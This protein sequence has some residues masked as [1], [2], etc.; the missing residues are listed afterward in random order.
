M[1]VFNSKRMSISIFFIVNKLFKQINYL[2]ILNLT[3]INISL[4]IYQIHLCYQ[5]MINSHKIKIIIT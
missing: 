3:A 1:C 4:I 2:K 5:N